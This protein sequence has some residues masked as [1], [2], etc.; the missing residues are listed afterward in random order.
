MTIAE[1]LSPSK[2]RDRE[3]SAQSEQNINILNPATLDNNS[4]VEMHISNDPNTS[5]LPDG[6]TNPVQALPWSEV[7]H[8]LTP[9]RNYDQV[10]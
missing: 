1:P 9:F 7:I 4:T 8:I 5:N 10:S 6:S 2:K 3:S